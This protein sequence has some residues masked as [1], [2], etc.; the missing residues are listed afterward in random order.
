MA[1][2]FVTLFTTIGSAISGFFGTKQAGINALSSGAL[3]VISLIQNSQL[4]ETQKEAA[5]AQVVSADSTSESWLA[6]NW[7]PAVATILWGM[8]FAMFCGY[9]PTFLESEMTRTKEWLLTT[10]TGCL[11]G[12]MPL[13]SV[14]KW[15]MEFF[16]HKTFQKI[17]NSILGENK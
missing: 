1:F 13:R 17:I 16:K 11:F 10:A 12:F 5:I 2:P 14:D 3:S 7:R 6:R 4:S 15:V 8:V 9:E